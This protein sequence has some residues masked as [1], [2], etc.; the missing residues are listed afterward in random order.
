VSAHYTG[1]LLDGTKFDSSVDRGEAFKFKIGQGQV[2]KGWDTGFASMKIGEKAVLKCAPEYAYG[3]NGSPPKIPA[4]AT[5]LFEV[6][7]L[8]FEEPKK[9][10][11]EMDDAE[12]LGEGLKAKEEGTA[13]FKAKDY[14]SALSSYG[15]AVD[16][17][18]EMESDE[19]GKVLLASELNAAQCCINLKDWSGA[20]AHAGQALEKDAASVK[21]LY[22]RGYARMKVGDMDRAKAD[23]Q[24]ARKLDATNKPVVAAL[25]ELVK[26]KKEAKIKEKAAFGGLFNKVSMYTEKADVTVRGDPSKNPI[27]YMDVSHGGEALGR[28][29]F[30]LFAHVVPKTAENF[31]CLCTGEKG[32][33]YKDSTFHRVIKDFM[34][35]GGDFTNHNGT[36]GKSIYGNKFDD[37]DFSLKH[38]TPFLLSMANSGPGTNGSQFFVTSRDTPHLDGKHVV[39]GKVVEGFELVTLIENCETAEQDKPAKDVLVTACGQLTDYV[40]PDKAVVDL[41]DVDAQVGGHDHAHADHSDSHAHNCA[42]DHDHAE[43]GHDDHAGGGGHDAHDHNCATDH[44]HADSSG[45]GHD[46]GH[47]HG[48]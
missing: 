35:Q 34:L 43:A 39:F 38:D 22:R 30:E 40:A 41:T 15:A 27:V 12:K 16:W 18:K 25:H 21:G 11:W 19:A 47:G 48:H 10:R 26:L 17:V 45:S 24:A 23:L 4:D 8:G 33:G 36:G 2:I 37:E 29:V 6:E 46:H 31:R 14:Q 44:D 7:L 1:T 5:L 32:F 20:A 13:S 28:I 9:E 42:T 3:K